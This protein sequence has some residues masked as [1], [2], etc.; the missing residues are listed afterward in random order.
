MD[1]TWIFVKNRFILPLCLT[2]NVNDFLRNKEGEG[3]PLE[4]L[5]ETSSKHPGALRNYMRNIAYDV[6]TGPFLNYRYSGKH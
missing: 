6:F 4:Q 2:E 1:N 3:N 5:G